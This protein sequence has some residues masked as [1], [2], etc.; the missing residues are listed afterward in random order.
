MAMET[1]RVSIYVTAAG[2][3]EVSVDE[4]FTAG[5]ILAKVK[6]SLEDQPWHGNAVV[7]LG[8][9]QFKPSEFLGDRCRSGG[10]G[11]HESGAGTGGVNSS[12]ATALCLANYSLLGPTAKA[13]VHMTTERRGITIQQIQK[14]LDFVSLMVQFWTGTYGDELGVPLTFEGFNLYHA[15]DWVIKPATA[16]QHGQGCSYVEAQ[17]A[18]LLLKVNTC[19]ATVFCFGFRLV[20]EVAEVQLPLWFVSHAWLEPIRLFLKC[21]QKHSLVRLTKSAYWV[22]AYAN[23][24]HNVEE[25]I[26]KNPR[27][28]SFY[29]AMQL[30]QGVLL[31]LDSQA[32]PF[33][34]IWCCFEESIAV[35]ERASNSLLLDVGATDGDDVAH[36]L[37]DGLAG[38][39]SRAQPVM[40][41][42]AKSRREK[43][44]PTEL[45]KEGL[46]VNIEQAS[47][48]QAADKTSILNSIAFPRSRTIALNSNYSKDHPSYQIVNRALASHFALAAMYTS[49]L[50]DQDVSSLLV[51][52]Q[53]DE[54][55]TSLQLSLTE[56]HEFTD[57]KLSTLLEHLPRCLQNLRLDLGFTGLKCF[58]VFPVSNIS[59]Q[60]LVLRF[61]GSL[62]SIAGFNTMLQHLQPSLR[63]LELW[64][65]NLPFLEDLEF[66]PGNDTLL[67]LQLVEL[68]LY[69]E[70]C[71]LVSQTSKQSLYDAAM[72]MRSR[73]CLQAWIHIE[74]AVVKQGLC[75]MSRASLKF[76]FCSA[77][78]SQ[79]DNRGATRGAPKDLS[80]LVESQG[81]P[82]PCSQKGCSTFHENLHG[83]CQRHRF[84][85]FSQKLSTQFH[86]APGFD[87][88]CC[89]HWPD[90]SYAS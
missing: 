28:S 73:R 6:T 64:F 82:F 24:Q 77:F 8:S 13:P 14:L 10:G 40:A 12:M 68:M 17:E 71:P 21:L 16:G 59:L 37:T 33:R 7:S 36:V 23:N 5:D 89:I 34:R 90:K 75:I 11:N 51:A 3:I 20:A 55:R 18:Q 58:P 43:S 57:E 41:L 48:T 31:V 25:D 67:R 15:N 84:Q 9:K 19:T 69:V 26:S 4:H 81:L 39:E 72:T 44:F 56:C 65:S 61:T 27:K 70:G 45:L 74:D 53:A 87:L 80:T 42:L 62:Q 46:A 29:K 38:G 76:P 85:R 50:Q 32:T 78:A 63:H 49:Y 66:G 1:R 79:S 54:A 83:Y 30:C 52:L 88:S 60:K 22:C 47:A 35:E 86:A 2:W